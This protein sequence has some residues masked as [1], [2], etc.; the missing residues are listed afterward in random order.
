MGVGVAVEK[1]F[2]GGRALLEAKGLRVVSLAHITK[3]KDGK[4]EF[5]YTE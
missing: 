4:I 2:Q 1:E 5:H 3:M